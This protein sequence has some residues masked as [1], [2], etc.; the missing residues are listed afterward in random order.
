MSAPDLH[1]TIEAVWRIESAKVIAALARMVRDVGLA[2]ELA[3]DALVTAL[4]R[5][6]STGI[7]DRPGAWLMA[8][9]KNRALDR[10][11]RHKRAE[12][13]H[14]EIGRLMGRTTSFSK[15]QLARAH[16]RLRELLEG[17]EAQTETTL[18]TPELKTC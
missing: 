7:P 12:R 16:E 1:R 6:P 4:E 14:A 10:L 17:K 15:S 11:R 18:C 9:A 3:Q 5:W 8:T 13:T 2:E